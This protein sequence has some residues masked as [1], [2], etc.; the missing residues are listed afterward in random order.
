MVFTTSS[1]V[2]V[3]VAFGL[4]CSGFAAPVANAEIPEPDA[5]EILSQQESVGAVSG[6]SDV[7]LSDAAEVPTHNNDGLLVDATINGLAISVPVAPEDGITSGAG[8]EAVVVGLPGAEHLSAGVP[9][10]E[11]VVQYSATSG[12]SVVPIVVDDGSIQI[13]VLLQDASAPERFEF[14]IETPAGGFVEL[15]DDGAVHFY[16]AAGE[17]LGG[18]LAP[19]A[20]DAHGTAVATHFEVVG[21]TIVQVVDHRAAPYKYPVVADP[22]QGR[23]LIA[24]GGWLIANQRFAVTPTDWGRANG[25]NPHAVDAYMAEFDSKFPVFRSNT[26]IRWQYFCHVQNAP[27]KS[28]WNLDMG[29]HRSTYP[30]YVRNLCN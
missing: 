9:L 6:S 7:R 8:D 23:A 20:A 14:P 22:Y 5:I 28:S 13:N 16:D 15:S 21:S 2:A 29:I 10:E 17:G 18:F 4:V 12:Y 27:L 30:D 11:G 26:Q 24:R 3:A 19:W 25:H 1:G